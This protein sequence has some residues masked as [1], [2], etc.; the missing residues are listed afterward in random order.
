MLKFKPENN[1][2][3]TS[4]L[5][6]FVSLIIHEYSHQWFGN[7]VT[8]K[9]WSDL[10]LNEG[11][12]YM[13]GDYEFKEVSIQYASTVYQSNRSRN[14]FSLAILIHDTSQEISVETL[15]D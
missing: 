6:D 9:W 11:F 10:W 14:I 3:E 15:L 8:M 5:D 1:F 7:L 4:E 2:R 13:F 12:A